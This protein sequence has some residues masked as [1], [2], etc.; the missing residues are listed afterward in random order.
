MYNIALMFSLFR[1]CEQQNSVLAFT[2]YT[3]G[4]IA[5]GAHNHIPASELC[6]GQHDPG[7][8]EG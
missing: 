3:D 4:E 7:D 1:S 2:L 6:G 8:G 5:R